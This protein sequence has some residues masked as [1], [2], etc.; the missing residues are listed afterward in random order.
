M[1][2]ANCF[3]VLSSQPFSL[4]PSSCTD[5]MSSGYLKFKFIIL[6]YNY[7][8]FLPVDMVGIFCQNQH[9]NCHVDIFF[10]VGFFM[11]CVRDWA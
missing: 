10:D 3:G 4:R 11:N 9:R 2:N 6:P 1:A 8:S 5:S 7:S